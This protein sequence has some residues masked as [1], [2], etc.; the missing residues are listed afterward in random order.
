MT[1]PASSLGLSV[2]ILF[3]FHFDHID[4]LTNPGL[5]L[6]SS[7]AFQ[8][9]LADNN[10][11]V[12][13]NTITRRHHLAVAGSEDAKLEANTAQP[14]DSYQWHC[15]DLLCLAA[16][17]LTASRRDW[18]RR[19]RRRGDTRECGHWRRTGRGCALDGNRA[20]LA[21]QPAVSALYQERWQ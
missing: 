7:S 3:L 20:G 1:I 11:A 15:I 5:S 12:H 8:T 18:R 13:P 21:L 19:S 2:V 17:Q 14:R 9:L 16:G 10:T 4:F 6:L